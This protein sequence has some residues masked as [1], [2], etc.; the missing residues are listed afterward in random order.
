MS[1]PAALTRHVG[2]LPVGAWLAAAAAGLYI[3]RHRVAGTPG[4]PATP[5]TDA[6]SGDAI[7]PSPDNAPLILSPVFYLPGG[8]GSSSSPVDPPADVPPA[9]NVPTPPAP[10]PTSVTNPTSSTSSTAHTAHATTPAKT[11]TK[12]KAPTGSR[13]VV[14]PG[15]TLSKIGARKGVDWQAIYSANRDVIEST[16]KR[17]GFSSSD[18]GHWIFPGE[19]LRIPS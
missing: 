12:K 19:L 17:H 3:S 10:S 7:D 11:S 13:Y 8:S 18:G 1:L 5:A 16:A 9:T 2:P 4:T 14:R 6:T 15:D